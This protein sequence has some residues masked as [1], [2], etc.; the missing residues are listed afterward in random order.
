MR[1]YFWAVG[2]F[3]WLESRELMGT[4]LVLYTVWFAVTYIRCE[5][6]DSA[7]FHPSVFCFD[8]V[9]GNLD[10]WRRMLLVNMSG[11]RATACKRT[12]LLPV[13]SYVNHPILEI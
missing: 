8:G 13:G 11:S 6:S 12:D 5:F 10:W 1:W 3:C 2:R 7:H 9:D 4:R